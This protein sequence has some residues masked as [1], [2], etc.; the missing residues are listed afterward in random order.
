LFT[1]RVL[2]LLL[3]LGRLLLLRRRSIKE[4]VNLLFEL[5]QSNLH[6][7]DRVTSVLMK[8]FSSKY[9]LKDIHE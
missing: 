2:L 6:F 4:L 3:L 8:G 7:L 1:A 5:F 9:L